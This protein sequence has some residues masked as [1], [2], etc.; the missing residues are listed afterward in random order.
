MKR[1]TF[2]VV[3]SVIISAASL[4]VTSTLFAQFIWLDQMGDKALAIEILKPTFAGNDDVTF[5]SSAIFISG[6]FALREDLR[7]V[8]ELPFAHA[9]VDVVVLDFINPQPI[10]ESESET[11]IGNPYIGLELRKAGSPV[12][13]ELGVRIPITPDD[14]SIASAIGRFADFD[15]MEAFAPDVFTVLGRI[16]FQSTSASHVRIRVRGGPTLLFNSEGFLE[17]DTELLLDYSAQVGYVTQKVSVM[18]GLT[19]RLFATQTEGDFGERSVHQLGAS[20]TLISGQVQPGI[21]LR[22]PIDDDLDDILD[23]VFGLNLSVQLK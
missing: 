16:N 18:G 7:L 21:H 11:I 19:G 17:D 3:V 10:K 2:Y 6:R 14:K 9:R 1:L 22:I 20:A 4:P 15:R 23:F 5:L 13:G 12:F 8:A